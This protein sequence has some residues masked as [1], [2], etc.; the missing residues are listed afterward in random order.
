ML[1]LKLLDAQEI[2]TEEDEEA[3]RSS[4]LSGKKADEYCDK[5]S[6]IL[7]DPPKASPCSPNRPVAL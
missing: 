5:I 4:H 7:W 1:L 2:E 6:A 3:I